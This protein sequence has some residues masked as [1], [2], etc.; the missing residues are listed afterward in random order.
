MDIKKRFH[1]IVCI[2]VLLLVPVTAGAADINWT[3][4]SYRVVAGAYIDGIGHEVERFGPPL[5]I[6]ADAVERDGACA[7]GTST[8]SSSEMYVRTDACS[9]GERSAYSS[10]EAS[11]AGTFTAENTLFL[12]DYSFVSNYLDNWI[13]MT[14][15]TDGIVFNNVYFDGL[16]GTI[17]V[18]VYEGHIIE[19]EYGMKSSSSDDGGESEAPYETTMN[20]SMSVVHKPIRIYNGPYYNSL[21]AA[22]DEALNNETIQILAVSLTGDLNINQPIS[23]TL[24]SGYDDIFTAAD[25]I[26]TLVGNMTVSDGDLTIADGT[27]EIL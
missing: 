12:L 15:L 1:I 3:T 20:Y 26:T 14:D 23:V 25:G 13:T 22:Y 8:I 21:Q 19:V 27:F 24:E 7:H 5:P 2:A 17:E 11:F 16:D 9:S 4:E 6:Y 18:P 10:A